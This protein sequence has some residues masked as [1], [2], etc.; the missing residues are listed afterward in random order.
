MAEWVF[1]QAGQLQGFHLKYAESM[2]H[3]SFIYNMSSWR[4]IRLQIICV[5]LFE[6]VRHIT[7]WLPAAIL[8]VR[9]SRSMAFLPIS[10]HYETF[11][12]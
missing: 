4:S 10:D 9:N 6:V 8:D 12:F 2:Q 3:Y 1:R 7:K 5:S 11:L